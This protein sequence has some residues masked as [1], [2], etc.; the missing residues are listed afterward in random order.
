M[1][2]AGTFGFVACPEDNIFLNMETDFTMSFQFPPLEI[3]NFV[4]LDV[5]WFL[6]KSQLNEILFKL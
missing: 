6:N 4:R 2:L 5:S 1:S 3:K